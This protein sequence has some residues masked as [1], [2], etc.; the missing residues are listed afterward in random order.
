MRL[1]LELEFG[2]WSL[3]LESILY[4]ADAGGALRYVL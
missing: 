1:E 3:G 4:A 2:A